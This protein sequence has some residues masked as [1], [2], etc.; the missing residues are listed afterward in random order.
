[1]KV[2]GAPNMGGALRSTETVQASNDPSMGKAKS[3]LLVSPVVKEGWYYGSL[4]EKKGR[5]K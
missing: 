2:G 5:Q 1:M 4:G 3:Q